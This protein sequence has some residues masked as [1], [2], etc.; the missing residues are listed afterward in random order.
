MRRATLGEGLDRRAHGRGLQPAQDGPQGR[1]PCLRPAPGDPQQEDYDHYYDGLTRDAQLLYVLAR[2]FPRRLAKLE[3]EDILRVAEPAARGEFNTM[4][5]ACVILALDAYAEAVGEPALQD[6]AA[7]EVR[8]GGRARAPHPARGH[9]PKVEFSPDAEK[10]RFRNGG[11]S[12]AFYQVTQAGFDLEPPAGE[13]RSGLEIYREYTDKDGGRIS[14]V[15]LGA[16]AEVR[17]RVRTL[18]G[19]G[20]SDVAVVDLLP[21]GSSPCW[22]PRTARPATCASPRPSP[23][24]SRITR[25]CARTGWCCSAPWAGRARVR[26][27]ASKAVNS[28][29]YTAPPPFAHSMYDRSLQAQGLKGAMAVK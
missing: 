15:E 16:E 8:R 23:A 25:T 21:A 18:D 3:G 19:R 14:E 26:G 12:L 17:L 9:V 6:L 1:G 22:T 24:G 27:T 20:H 2:H 10:I 11:A 5:G 29:R 13:V 7:A 28:G 4:S